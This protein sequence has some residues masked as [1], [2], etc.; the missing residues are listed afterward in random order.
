[1][2]LVHSTSMTNFNVITEGNAEQVYTKLYEIK[3][4]KKDG[5][6]IM[7]MSNRKME[8]SW[9]NYATTIDEVERLTG[10]DFLAALPDGGLDEDGIGCHVCGRFEKAGKIRSAGEILVG[11]VLVPAD[12][13]G[14]LIRSND[15]AVQ[16]LAAF[17][18]SQKSGIVSRPDIVNAVFVYHAVQSGNQ[19][20]VIGKRETFDA[21]G[22]YKIRMAGRAR[23]S[24][25]R[26]EL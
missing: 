3:N 15:R 16:L 21:V 17:A 7:P 6:W 20:G 10:I 5:N 1:M 2:I 22:K 19:S 4:E 23:R 9:T 18:Q 25:E 26:D 11:P 8:R 13:H 12:A 14:F 24:V